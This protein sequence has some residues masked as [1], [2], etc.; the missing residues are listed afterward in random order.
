MSVSGWQKLLCVCFWIAWLG[1]ISLHPGLAKRNE[2]I[3]NVSS[4][5][6]LTLGPELLFYIAPKILYAYIII[7]YINLKIL[8]LPL[9]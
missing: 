9:I 3:S 4:S 1:C 2:I 7:E 8:V 6:L 5:N